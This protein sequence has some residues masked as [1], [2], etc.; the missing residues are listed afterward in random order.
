MVGRSIRIVSQPSLNKLF[1][2]PPLIADLESRNLAI[3][4]QTID[5]EFIHV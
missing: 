1:F 2:E 5:G 3:R 4:H